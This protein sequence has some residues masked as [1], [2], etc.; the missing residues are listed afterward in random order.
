MSRIVDI[1]HTIKNA[2][3]EIN[4]LYNMRASDITNILNNSNGQV[5]AVIDAFTLGYVQG[6]K[7][8]KKGCAIANKNITNLSHIKRY[9]II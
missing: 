2:Q 4:P 5:E 6:V 1:E 8:Q 7:A 3:K 9:Y